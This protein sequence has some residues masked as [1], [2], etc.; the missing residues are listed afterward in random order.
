L[1]Y[2]LH[3]LVAGLIF[4]ASGLLV[5]AC[6]NRLKFTTS[7]AALAEQRLDLAQKNTGVGIFELD[8]ENCTAFVSYSLCQMLGRKEVTPGEID[9]AIWLGGLRADHVEES[10]RVMQERIARGELRYER[11]Q[12]ITRPDGEICWVLNRVELEASATGTLRV[13]RGVAVDI[14]ERKQ[15]DERLQRAQNEVKQQLEDVGRLHAFS[16]NLVIAGDD[17]SAALQA[18]LDVTIELYRARHGIVSLCNAEKGSCQTVAQ[19]GFADD[20]IERHAEDSILDRH[21]ALAAEEELQG[22]HSVP[23]VSAHGEIMGVLSVMRAEPLDHF[24]REQGI[25]EVCAES[26]AVVVERERARAA[27]IKNERRFSVALESSVVPFTILTPVRRS[28]GLIVD[29]T[30]TYVNPAAARTLGREVA[31]LIGR[32]IGTVLPNAWDAPGLFARYV[33]VLQSGEQREFEVQTDATNQGVRWYNVLAAPLQGSVAVWFTNITA[34]KKY[35]ETLREADRRKDEFLATL[36]H[37]L[38]NPLAP[39]RQGVRIAGSTKATEAQRRWSHAIIERQVQHMSLLLDDLLDVS[40]IGRG[41]L[42]LR[43]S[44]EL[45]SVVMDTAVEAARPHLE[46]KRHRLQKSLPP[47]PVILEIDPVR[48]AQVL[49]NLLTNA[50]KYTDPE[51]QIQISAQREGPDFVI[52]VKDNGI[53]LTEAQQTQVFDM[54]SQVPAAM[55]QSQGGLGIGLA[56]ARGLVELHGGAIR[57][58]SAGLG[59]GTEVIVQ[60]PGSCIVSDRGEGPE[61]L[62]ASGGGAKEELKRCILIADDDADAADS[63]AELLRL[64]GHEV[65]LAYDGAQALAMFARVEPHAALLD[66]GMPNLS[67]LEVVRAIRQQPGGERATLIAVTGWAQDRDRR[68]ALE[69]GFDHHLTKPMLPEVICDLIQRGRLIETQS[70]YR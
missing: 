12:R 54:F 56:L 20:T 70:T 13:A 55:E 35:E 49:G 34:R 57:A 18:L 17:I 7:R 46:A 59:R 29:F 38:R 3:D 9:L 48:I 44:H 37:E 21:R 43:T 4:A 23:L 45:L 51:G 53:G 22:V 32:G 40:R 62:K 10:R 50:A 1:I 16:Q 6:A 26:A 61:P 42:L 39:I 33:G 14:T 52:R 63:L 65:H 64:E 30:W 36:A 24:E 31:D 58:S 60:L 69:A 19:A 67:G 5:V 2:S 15:M 27:A 68:L 41:T 47:N 25:A 8:F 66:I 28:D 11:E